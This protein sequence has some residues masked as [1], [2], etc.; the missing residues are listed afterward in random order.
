MMRADDG[1]ERTTADWET[2]ICVQESLFLQ[3]TEEERIS[4]VILLMDNGES[5][6]RKRLGQ[7]PEACMAVS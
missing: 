3:Q 5:L 7:H 4:Y 6:G 2:V 1:H